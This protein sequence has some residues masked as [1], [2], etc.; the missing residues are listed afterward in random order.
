MEVNKISPSQQK[1]S[2]I[3]TITSIVLVAVIIPTTL[4][5]GY[6]FIALIIFLC[7]FATKEILE[8]PG[9]T[10]YNLATKIVVYLFVF[11][12]LFWTIIK[13][14]IINEEIFSRA[15]VA[16]S[17]MS[18]SLFA[19]MLYFFILFFISIVDKRVQLS[20]VTLLFTMGLILALGFQSMLYLRLFPNSS[21]INYLPDKKVVVDF[22]SSGL[23]TYGTY[24]KDYYAHYNY[25]GFKQDLA[26]SVLLGFTFIGVWLSD[27]GAYFTGML[28]GKH[29]MN[30]RISP[31]KTW[32]GFFGGIIFSVIFSISSALIMEYCF[33]LP[34]I[35]GLVQLRFSPLL[36]SMNVFGGYSFINVIILALIMPSVGA[37]GGLAFSLVKRTYGI[38]DFGKIFPGHGGV[39]DRFDSV[40]FSSIAMSIVIQFIANGWS[41]LV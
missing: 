24:F 34:L 7:F 40:L 41:F 37:L 20:D 17:E 16:L 11:S 31:H 28:F 4:F 22:T 29:R 3:R 26:S 2:K 12:F 14:S 5:G 33:N 1:D 19:I 15:S 35:P 6:F 32:E 39:I 21:G 9:K 13:S 23:T 18:V 38:K 27:V 25:G 10:K 8:V 36:K 30:P